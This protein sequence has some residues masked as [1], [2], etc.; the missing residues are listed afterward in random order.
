MSKRRCAMGGVV[1]VLILM[2]VQSLLAES[3]AEG[4]LYL[5]IAI[6]AGT[7]PPAPT[8]FADLI[9]QNVA[10][11]VWTEEEGL[12]QVLGLFADELDA[13]E[14]SGAYRVEHGEGSGAVGMA[15]TYLENGADA[16]VQAEIERLLNVIF[17]DPER[18][19]LYSEPEPA[20]GSS[21]EI[22]NEEICRELWA[23]GFPTNQVIICFVESEFSAG[24]RKIRVYVPK[25]LQGD[26][27]IEAAK[28]A[29]AEAIP[30]AV[31][32]FSQYGVIQRD[33]QIVFSMLPSSKKGVLAMTY[34]PSKDA[35]PAESGEPCT[36]LTYPTGYAEPSDELKHIVIHEMFHCFQ[37]D[38][39]DVLP[40]TDKGY[41][42]TKWWIEGSA[43]YFTHLALQ[44]DNVKA[45]L[46]KNRVKKFESDSLN[47]SI[48][49]IGHENYVFFQYLSDEAVM[50]KQGIIDFLKTVDGTALQNRDA[51]A[52]VLA[53]YPDMNELFHTFG[54]MFLEG[55]LTDEFGDRLYATPPQ[56][57]SLSPA[58]TTFDG[59]GEI[60][61]G[62][63]DYF[64]L[65]RYQVSYK[66][67]H[68]FSQTNE[69]SGRIKH[70]AQLRGIQSA[71]WRPLPTEL[72]TCGGDEVYLL[73]VTH[74]AVDEPSQ[75]YKL[76][77][78]DVEDQ[79]CQ[80]FANLVVSGAY[81]GRYNGISTFSLNDGNVWNWSATSLPL[82]SWGTGFD[83]EGFAPGNSGVYEI[84]E[85]C[86]QQNEPYF[87][88]CI[89]DVLIGEYGS[90]T[91]TITESDE[92]YI[93]GFVDAE[94]VE[95][96]EAGSFLYLQGEF[97]A[98]RDSYTAGVVA[99]YSGS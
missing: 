13:N 8:D 29:F 64:V 41:Q 23:S 45:Q 1:F 34:W 5:P 77:L 92:Q 14:V 95:D 47:E 63:V 82:G 28:Q 2:G 80:C 21:R 83:F 7:P 32:S 25:A 97:R 73:L 50:G 89:E 11:G 46:L 55:T 6:T 98:P 33:I 35:W 84:K 57:Y 17:P 9:A 76:D 56:S 66:T 87:A 85:G 96:I 12:L 81:S 75:E 61:A 67:E 51:Q 69:A 59:V 53:D 37:M 90:G 31:Q 38:N 79:D 10:D 42:A 91:I 52:G 48:V 16:A 40:Y 49:D 24:D 44:P 20:V 19:V 78:Y 18:I 71:P 58:D 15:R 99:C 72:T 30:L 60:D 74:T 36:I 22:E 26:P 65:K 3:T 88:G 4:P 54:Q 43:E 94:L 93:S 27:Q 39:L 86:F 62:N 68:R 70:T